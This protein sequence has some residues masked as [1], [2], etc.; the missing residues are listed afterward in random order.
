MKQ[1]SFLKL[2]VIFSTRGREKMEIKLTE[3]C[4]DY[5]KFPCEIKDVEKLERVCEECP[6]T[7]LEQDYISIFYKNGGIKNG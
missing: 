3:F 1:T 6:I 7:K 5:C 4:Q 2:S